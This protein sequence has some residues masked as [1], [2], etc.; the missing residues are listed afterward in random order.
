[1]AASLTSSDLMVI[2]L[3][4]QMLKILIFPCHGGAGWTPDWVKAEV[5]VEIG[6]EQSWGVGSF[7]FL[8]DLW[9]RAAL[10]SF[11]HSIPGLSPKI[12]PLEFSHPA[13]RP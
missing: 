11:P 13:P 6:T 7:P 1:M 2:L 10:S 5:R 8:S 4:V 9:L 3:V 12:H